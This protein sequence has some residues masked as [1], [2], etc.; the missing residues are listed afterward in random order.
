[1]VNLALES[2]TE[3]SSGYTFRA[4]WPSISWGYMQLDGYSVILGKIGAGCED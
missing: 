4:T 2:S 3:I 1:M